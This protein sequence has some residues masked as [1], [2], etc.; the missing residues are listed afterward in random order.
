MSPALFSLLTTSASSLAFASV[1]S[2]ALLNSKSSVEPRLIAAGF[3]GS[4]FA[5]GGGA[6][7]GLATGAG[8]GAGVGAGFCASCVAQ[9]PRAMEKTRASVLVFIGL[10][11]LVFV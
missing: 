3:C 8:A 5:T 2:V 10:P 9:A 6:G 1:V 11:L 4:G 7:A